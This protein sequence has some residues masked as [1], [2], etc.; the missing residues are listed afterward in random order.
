MSLPTRLQMDWNTAVL[1]V[2]WTPARSGDDRTTSVIIRESPVTRLTTPG[3][4][5]ASSRMFMITQALRIEVW[6]GFQSTT[7][8][9]SAGEVTR[10]PPMAVKLKGEIA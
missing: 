9:I 4:M 2:K 10:F 8:P 5:P 6:A 7:L 1:P 3:G